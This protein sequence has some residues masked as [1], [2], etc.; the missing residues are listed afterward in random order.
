MQSCLLWAC[1]ICVVLLSLQRKDECFVTSD[2]YTS[3]IM[4][5]KYNEN[6]RI[7][8]NRKLNITNTKQQCI[9]SIH[10]EW[11]S[12]QGVASVGTSSPEISL[13]LSHVD[14]LT[15]SCSNLGQRGGT[16]RGR[17]LYRGE[18]GRRWVEKG[19]TE[20]RTWAIELVTLPGLPPFFVLQFI[21]GY[22]TVK[23]KSGEREGLGTL[24]WMMSGGCEEDVGWVREGFTF[25]RLH[26]RMLRS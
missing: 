2:W 20:L 19:R 16:T 1:D 23:W 24:M 3:V 13:L 7:G 14:R 5:L 6:F 4:Q 12:Q 9:Q 15:L 8:L 11:L 21:F 17:G 22:D 25:N 18:G 10:V 26:H